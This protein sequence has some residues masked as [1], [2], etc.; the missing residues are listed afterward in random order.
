MTYLIPG[1]V[2][3]DM[4]RH[5]VRPLSSPT[6]VGRSETCNKPGTWA[7]EDSQLRIRTPSPIRFIKRRPGPVL[8]LTVSSKNTYLVRAIRQARVDLPSPPWESV[9]IGNEWAEDIYDY[10]YLGIV[11]SPDGTLPSLE[12]ELPEY[13]V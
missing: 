1:R 5:Q 10:R 6:T 9:C 11:I 8:A 13:A 4:E 7:Y 12:D 3:I 2:E